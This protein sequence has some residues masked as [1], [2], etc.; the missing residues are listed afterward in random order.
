MASDAAKQSL[1][2]RLAGELAG[3]LDATMAPLSHHPVWLI[4]GYRLEGQ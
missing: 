2:D 3:D 4:P 1:G